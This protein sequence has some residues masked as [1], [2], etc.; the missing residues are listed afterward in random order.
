MCRN[1]E[2]HPSLYGRRIDGLLIKTRRYNMATCDGKVHSRNS[3]LVP[4]LHGNYVVDYQISGNRTEDF[5]RKSKWYK[6][7]IKTGRSF[8]KK[9]CQNVMKINMGSGRSRISCSCDLCGK[10]NLHGPCQN[11]NLVCL[12]PD[13]NKHLAVLPDG[14]INESI[15]RFLIGNVL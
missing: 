12:C 15:K 4:L 11:E 6:D 10:N 3:N 9:E 2:R 5:S 8:N 1:Y 14:N 13:C 7:V